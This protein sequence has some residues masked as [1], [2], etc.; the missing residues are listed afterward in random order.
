MQWPALVKYCTIIRTF[1][2][3]CHSIFLWRTLFWKFGWSKSYFYTV[4]IMQR[5][6][7]EQPFHAE[8]AVLTAI[9]YDHFSM[10]DICFGDRHITYL[11]GGFQGWACPAKVPHVRYH[12]GICAWHD[13]VRLR[14]HST[15]RKVTGNTGY[16][17]LSNNHHLHPLINVYCQT[18]HTH[19]HYDELKDATTIY[20]LFK[21]ICVL[22]L[23]K[24][25]LEWGPFVSEQEDAFGYY[26]VCECVRLHH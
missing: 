22:S 7:K 15:H 24:A 2:Q 17:H 18:I 5:L 6:F 16:W 11:L 1:Q 4:F 19:T 10:L 3:F 21:Q 20:C 9:I 26:I 14:L 23:P 8:W 25:G 13:P 12:D